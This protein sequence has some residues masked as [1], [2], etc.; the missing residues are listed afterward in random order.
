[1]TL[2]SPLAP[3]YA[4]DELRAQIPS[5]QQFVPLNHCSQAPATHG[6]LEA[7]QAFLRSW[8]TT[9]MDWDAWLNEVEAARTSFARMIGA[10]ARDVAVFSSVSHATAAVASALEFGGGR[11]RIVLTDA[12]FPTVG[13]VWGW[14]ER[15]G[16]ELTW[17]SPAGDGTDA[18]PVV[19]ALDSDV[20]LLSIAHGHYETGALLPLEALVQAAHEVGA[21]AF[22]DAYQTMGTRTIDVRASEVDFLACGALKYLMGVAGIAFLYV[23]PGLSERLEPE[24]TGWFGRT[25]PFAF[26]PKTL[27][28]ADG[29]RR[30]DSGTP[31]LL[32]AYIARAGLDYVLDIGV[33]PVAEWTTHLG[34]VAI[35]QAEALGLR[36]LGPTDPAAR[37]CNTAFDCGDVEGHSVE[38]Q[39]R[40][41]GFVVSARGRAI[42]LAPHGHNS[43]E[44]MERAVQAVAG[45][46]NRPR[47]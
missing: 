12:E 8:E 16:A 35:G 10:D 31:P 39:L 3:P 19:E 5:F 47:A 38:K 4:L 41:A 14:Q 15:R 6:T 25:D 9:G 37:S 18:T 40:T 42:R 29:A 32:P 28:W 43:V 36:L 22:V 20:R 1:M 34:A 33:D 7:A 17:A 2:P 26:D 23:R 45:I 11:N 21:L 30:F 13:H 46:L 27:D 44:D 24:T